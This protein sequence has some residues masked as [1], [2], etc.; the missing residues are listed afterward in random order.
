MRLLGRW[1]MGNGRCTKSTQRGSICQAYK[2]VMAVANVMP[3]APRKNR[4]LVIMVCILNAIKVFAN[5]GNIDGRYDHS[6]NYTNDL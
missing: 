4:R 1:G 6:P 3:A 5:Y 2:P